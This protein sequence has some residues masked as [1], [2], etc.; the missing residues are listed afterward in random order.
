MQNFLRKLEHYRS[1]II[2]KFLLICYWELGSLEGILLFLIF[3]GNW[4]TLVAC[5][6]LWL[7]RFIYE[8][9]AISWTKY[10]APYIS[11]EKGFRNCSVI[12]EKLTILLIRFSRSG[13]ALTW[14]RTQ[15]TY[16]LS[17]FFNLINPSVLFIFIQNF[18]KADKK[19]C[20]ETSRLLWLLLSN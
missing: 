14:P 12:L 11:A 1:F 13:F 4:N 18:W 20:Q 9:T 15:N 10:S 6:R 16:F 7:Y 17:I 3:C 19:I 5:I 8:H 2:F